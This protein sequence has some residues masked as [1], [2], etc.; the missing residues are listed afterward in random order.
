[1]WSGWLLVFGCLAAW[2]YYEGKLHN[3]CAAKHETD[4][5]AIYTV[6]HSA[7]CHQLRHPFSMFGLDCDKARLEL[8]ERV[9]DLKVWSCHREEHF[10]LGSWMRL[11]GVVLLGCV[12]GLRLCAMR[13]NRL[14]RQN[15]VREQARLLRGMSSK[16]GAYS[17]PEYLTH[18][19]EDGYRS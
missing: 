10:L 19:D 12:M 7:A 16:M 2:L 14:E 11:S 13:Q 18:A 15:F 9:Q 8:D 1:M 4:T 6:I 5:A 3:Y 17:E